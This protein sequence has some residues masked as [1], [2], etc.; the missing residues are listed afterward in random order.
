VRRRA[1]ARLSQGEQKLVLLARAIGGGPRLLLLDEACQALDYGRRRAAL[2]LLAAIPLRASGAALVH[3]SHHPDELA[4][5]G[6]R[7]LLELNR[8]TGR[9]TTRPYVPP[10]APAAG[11]WRAAGGGGAGAEE[12]TD[13]ASVLVPHWSG[14]LRPDQNV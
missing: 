6:A 13:P 11:G 5:A 8:E 2:A 4:A 3:V 10:A 1:F 9:A 12:E 14:K 7:H